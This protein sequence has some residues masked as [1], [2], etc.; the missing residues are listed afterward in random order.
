MEAHYR[1]KQ[2]QGYLKIRDTIEQ[3]K[4]N[5][6]YYY[7]YYLFPNNHVSKIVNSVL[8]ITAIITTIHVNA[9]ITMTAEMEVGTEIT[10]V[11]LTESAEID[12]IMVEKDVI[13]MTLQEQLKVTAEDLVVIKTTTVLAPLS[14]DP[15]H[16]HPLGSIAMIK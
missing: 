13:M 4:V 5:D 6:C 10:V 16:D 1:G 8:I 12:I 7:Y 14:K 11:I 15:V 9:M 2:H 3:M